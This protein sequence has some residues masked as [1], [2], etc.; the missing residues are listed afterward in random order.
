[1]KDRITTRALM[2]T[3][4][5]GAC[6]AASVHIAH[7][8]HYAL[9]VSLPWLSSPT[10]VPWWTFT[11][12]AVFLIPRTGIATLQGLLA[13]VIGF[14][15]MSLV[16]GIITEGV[17]WVGRSMKKSQARSRDNP[18]PR[19]ELW[20]ALLASLLSALFT[21]SIIVF[22]PEFS[23]MGWDVK[24]YSLLIRLSIGVLAVPIA[25]GIAKALFFTG[26]DPQ[27]I[28]QEGT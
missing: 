27:G 11:L 16:T 12:V 25:Y 28:L 23:V 8:L 14:G 19:Y 17:M 18:I 20:W 4:V 2:A 5:L 6:G 22:V 1:M 9:K 26:H 3:V 24:L 15:S 10:P 7:F 13:A 21:Y